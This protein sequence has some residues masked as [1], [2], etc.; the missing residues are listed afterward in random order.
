MLLVATVLQNYYDIT[1]ILSGEPLALY[2]YDGPLLFK[3]FKDLL[4]FFILAC[5]LLW[6]L[7]IKK[8]PL[9]KISIIIYIFVAFAAI[10]SL[11]INDIMTA[12]IGLR[13]AFPFLIFFALGD[14]TKYFDQ[15]RASHWLLLG[16]LI[17]LFAQIYQIFN[18][19]PVYGEV[20][21]GI[22]ARTPGIFL[23][24]N[25]TAFFACASLA[26]LMTC[27]NNQRLLTVQ[28]AIIALAICILTQSGT[29]IIVCLI[30]ILRLISSNSTTLFL[31]IALAFVG[32]LLP[33]LNSLTMREDYIALSGG[34]RLSVLYDISKAAA[35]S[36]GDFGTYT[37]ASNLM[38]DDPQGMI[39]VDSLVASWLGNFGIFSIPILFM[40]WLFVKY[41]MCDID[42]KRAMPCVVVLSL[43]SL[44]TVVFEA[45][46]MNL[47]LAVGIW[48][49]RKSPAT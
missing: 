46:P 2:K 47:Y 26:C 32:L 22:P 41:Y 1:A 19:P 38:S 35:L 7:S 30:L 25:S 23:A 37:N 28:A 8:F 43:F 49:S 48:L 24:P 6:A 34:G 21:P 18:M 11:L 33:N 29:G 27:V 17:C 40:V 15:S 42:W 16:M 45:F 9:K 5:I 20:L 44:T 31:I 3:I 10:I 12:I 13:W 14:W 4:Y 36:F 39:A